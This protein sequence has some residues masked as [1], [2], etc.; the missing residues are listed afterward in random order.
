MFALVRVPCPASTL[1]SQHGLVDIIYSFFGRDEFGRRV[2]PLGVGSTII[3]SI[4]LISR[5]LGAKP[6]PGHRD[7]VIYVLLT[8]A[9]ALTTFQSIK[10]PRSGD[11]VENTRLY[12]S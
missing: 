8:H 5:L 2:K 6:N 11:Q 12:C 7:R 9:Q 4:I 3:Y 1:K 10:R